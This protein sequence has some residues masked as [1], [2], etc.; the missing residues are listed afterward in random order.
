LVYAKPDKKLMEFFDHCQSVN[1]WNID[2]DK[3]TFARKTGLEL[4]ENAFDK[5]VSR[6]YL[7]LTTFAG[8]VEYLNDTSQHSQFALRFYDK[9]GLELEE[10]GK[11]VKEG[12]REIET[13]DQDEEYFRLMLKLELESVEHELSRSQSSEERGMANLH[14]YLDSYYLIMKLRFLCATINE[15]HIYG[16]VKVDSRNELL[17][18]WFS[19][20]YPSMPALA[21]VYF[22]AFNVLSGIDEARNLS[23]FL[24]GLKKWESSATTTNST[25]CSELN[26]YLLNYY[27]RK[28]G[29]GDVEALPKVYHFYIE[30]LEKGWLLENGKIPPEHFKNLLVT[31]CR[32]GFL[33][34][35]TAFYEQYKVRLTDDQSGAV[36]EY[37]EAVLYFYRAEYGTLIQKI[38]ALIDSKGPIKTDQYYGLDMRCLLLK[39]YYEMLLLSDWDSFDSIDE[40]INSLLHA[41]PGY[42]ARKNLPR[43]KQLRFDN[44]RK[45]IQRLYTVAFVVPSSETIPKMKELLMEFRSSSNL[46]DKAWFIQ[47]ASHGKSRT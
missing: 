20:K 29:S 40:K 6:L 34:K 9:K 35:A 32:M 33:D 47:K 14:H 46:P 15:Q 11:K 16:D 12:K 19:A 37:N 17:D 1:L 27:F 10:F 18:S 41:F 39:A 21:Q 8:M 43:I 22:H 7:A 5:L 31:F 38:E 25:I 13:R 4:T 3:A 28:L 2:I 26:G 42:I 45:S 23:E 44:F 24:A 36:L 30:A